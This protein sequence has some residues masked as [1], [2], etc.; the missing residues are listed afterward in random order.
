[1]KYWQAFVFTA[2]ITPGI[3]AANGDTAEIV[4]NLASFRFDK[5]GQPQIKSDS[6][7]PVLASVERP[8]RLLILPITFADVGFDRFAG[9][10][11]Q[12][13]KNRQYL[14]TLL[15]DGIPEQPVPG[16][17][18]DYYRHQ[19]RGQY[20]ITGDIFPTVHLPNPLQY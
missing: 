14:Q 17:L 12:E 6:I 19:S 16:T 15:F 3:A 1:M 9:E 8:H 5:L 18:S 11:D 10:P 13:I 2:C 7:K 20:N 4:D